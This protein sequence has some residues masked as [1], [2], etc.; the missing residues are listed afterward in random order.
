VPAPMPMYSLAVLRWVCCGR[1]PG[2]IPCASPVRAS[3]LGGGGR[4]GVW[5]LASSFILVERTKT[6]VIP[7]GFFKI[8]ILGDAMDY[9][10]RT[11]PMECSAGLEIR[12]V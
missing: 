8:H 6:Q 4:L 7:P 2:D 3:S 9:A 5:A 1:S 12:K 11:R 10:H